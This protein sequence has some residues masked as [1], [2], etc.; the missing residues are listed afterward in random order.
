ML[1]LFMA[2][3]EKVHPGLQRG[4]SWVWLRAETL[5]GAHVLPGPQ[6]DALK[7]HKSCF[8]VFVFPQR[9]TRIRMYL[10]S[11]LG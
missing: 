3:W 9:I 11:D 7:D 6:Q 4:A 8:F 2:C 1:Q 5:L 10:Q